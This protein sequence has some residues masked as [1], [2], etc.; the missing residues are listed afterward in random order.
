M[1][2]AALRFAD[3]DLARNIYEI[4]GSVVSFVAASKINLS[5]G[6]TIMYRCKRTRRNAYTEAPVVHPCDFLRGERRNGSAKKLIYG[7][8]ILRRADVESTVRRRRALSSTC[9]EAEIA[10][11]LAAGRRFSGLLRRRSAARPFTVDCRV[12]CHRRPCD[13]RQERRR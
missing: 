9:R 6:A 11:I 8:R 1:S 2:Y 5:L 7:K 12:Q 10:T 13:K 4:E 3:R